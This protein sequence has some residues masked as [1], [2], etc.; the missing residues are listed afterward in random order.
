[1]NENLSKLAE[2]MMSL[3]KIFWP[4]IKRIHKENQVG[5]NPCIFNNELLDEG[6]DETFDRICG[7]NID[8]RW[9]ENLLNK[10]GQKIITPEFL[11]KPALQEWLANDEVKNDFKIIARDKI[12]GSDNDNK[13][14][15]DRLTFFYSE[16]TGEREEFAAGPIQV[17]ITVLA[18]G[19]F[20]SLNDPQLKLA[21]MMQDV[22][23]TCKVGFQNIDD[24]IYG[25]GKKIK[26]IGGKDHH[27]VKAHSEKALSK[28]NILLKRR[29][30]EP[31]R[32]IREINV[33]AEQVSDEDGD[34]THASNSVKAEVLY[35]A[36]RLQVTNI[37]TTSLSKK[38]VEKLYQIDPSYDVRIIDAFI[39]EAKEDTDGALRILRDVDDPDGRATLF[40]I[41]FRK[42]GE[43]EALD[44]FDD[45]NGNKLPGFFTGLGWCNLAI[46][47]A[48]KDR[49]AQASE[50]LA[51]LRSKREEWPDLAYVEGVLNTALMLPTEFRHHLLKGNIF[52]LDIRPNQGDIVEKIRS[53]AISCFSEAV[54]LLHKSN[55]IERAKV[56][57]NWLLWLRL[58]DPNPSI[59]NNAIIEIQETISQGGQLA[60]ELT[61]LAHIFDIQFDEIPVKKYLINRSRLG[62]LNDEELIAEYFISKSKMSTKEFADYV[63]QNYNRLSKVFLKSTLTGILIESLVRDGQISKARLL[64]K[65]HKNDFVDC[66]FDRFQ[67]MIEAQD[68]NDPADQL[69]NLYQE[70]GT[71]IDLQNL[72]AYYERKQ[73]WISLHPYLDEFFSR[74][75]TIKNAIKLVECKFKTFPI[76]SS[77][78]VK[79]IDSNHDL[80]RLSFDLQSAKSWALLHIGKFKEAERIN[81]ELLKNR[82]N[83]NDLLLDINLSLQT[84]NWERF[85]VIIDHVWPQRVDLDSELLMQLASIAAES[86]STAGRAT[87]LAQLAIKKASDNPSILINAYSLCVKL[88]REN[89]IDSDVIGRA[90]DHSSEKGP[91]W[92]V[93]IRTM[94]EEIMPEHRARANEIEKALF[95]GKIPFHLA[96][97]YLN[98]PLSTFLLD[99]P[100]RNEIQSDGR[101]KIVIPVISGARRDVDLNPDWVISLDLTS[102]I[103]LFHLNII[104]HA[105][106]AFRQV[107]LSPDVM[108]SLLNERNYLRFHQPSRVIEAEAIRGFIDNKVL[109]VDHQLPDPP[110]WL[111][112]EVGK[113]LAEMLEASRLDRCRVVHT[114]PIYKINTLMEQEA[115]LKEYSQFVISTKSFLDLVFGKSFVDEEYF[116]TAKQFFELR[117]RA[118]DIFESNF[119]IL[120]KPLYLDDL[121]VAYFYKSGL[122]YAIQNAGLDILIHPSTKANQVAILSEKNESQRNANLIDNI[123]LILKEALEKGDA[124]FMSRNYLNEKDDLEWFYQCA[125][126]LAHLMKDVSQCDA[127]CIDDRFFN[128]HKTITDESGEN[129][130]TLCI[131]DLIRH[132]QKHNIISKPEKLKFYHKLRQSGFAFIPIFR[133]EVEIYLRSATFDEAGN[134]RESPEMRSLK[135]ILLRIRLRKMILYPDEINFLARLQILTVDAIRKLWSDD[136]IEIERLIKLSDW[137]WSNIAPSPLDW[138]KDLS[139]SKTEW[140]PSEAFARHFSLLLHSQYLLSEERQNFF[141]DWIEQYIIDPL[142][143]ANPELI[144]MLVK[145]TKQHIELSIEEI[146]KDEHLINS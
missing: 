125:P 57:Q 24:G 90:L 143:P 45:Q 16:K 128:K 51:A 11:R 43:D 36:T 110:Q 30:T 76:V 89:A 97:H 61:P 65:Q 129:V 127:V 116:K 15:L 50:I 82:K 140:N 132:F 135:H 17:I 10:I 8:D 56:A 41:L 103:I 7:G 55:Q 4:S 33:I 121:V 37:K 141:R 98:Q 101:K 120:T 27:V 3:S 146:K 87:E 142:L 102:I 80:A 119:K 85:P 108:I 91:V 60:T 106:K 78:I 72:V 23:Q 113:D 38:Y 64:L 68:G 58:T 73:D 124:F 74:E 67:L 19:Y 1:M 63:E 69:E 77:Q 42:K 145:Y 126:S 136:S 2:P 123:R 28:L 18:M 34:L 9:W 21:G 94:I 81:R 84:G 47:L 29:S 114:F 130:P 144:E 49:W 66:D 122:L 48:N 139:P 13:D 53:H 104:G 131:V 46:C 99:L 88:G 83:Q 112:D 44:W 35:W 26:T 14:A 111:V 93:N 117:D 100:L 31:D 133:D 118:Q 20:G 71:L 137:A 32:V 25:L 95:D 75:R 70:T 54:V 138:A 59:A 115:D 5:Q 62:G 109:K 39:K 86:D 107:A 79:F 22:A 6:L 92:K 96:A 134:L 40:L 52:L 12:M 105:F